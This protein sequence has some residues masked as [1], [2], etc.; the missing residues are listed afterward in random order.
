[1]KIRKERIDV[2][3]WAAVSF[4][5]EKGVGKCVSSE[6]SSRRKANG[7]ERTDKE[8]GSRTEKWK[9]KWR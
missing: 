7:I 8:R 1:M 3:K 9:R 2:I 4:M 5:N 6:R